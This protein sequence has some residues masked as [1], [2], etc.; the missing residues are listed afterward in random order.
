MTKKTKSPLKA[1]TV[2]RL[3]KLQKYILEEPKR[4][5]LDTWGEIA[6][7]KYYKKIKDR[8]GV[9]EVTKQKPPCGTVGCIAGSLCVIGKMVKP[10]VVMKDLE[11]TETYMFPSN[12][13]EMAADYLGLSL[14]DAKK[15]F[16]LQ[17]WGSPIGWPEEYDKMLRNH[18][19][20][21]KGYAKVAVARIEHFIKTGE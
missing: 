3:R 1:L 21:T 8:Y 15:L 14:S 7:P 16:F 13:P 10:T 2:Q 6:N 20:G 9:S 4:F 19:P 12:T 17:S 5:N 11:G 18:N